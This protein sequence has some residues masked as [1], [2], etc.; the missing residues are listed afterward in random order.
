MAPELNDTLTWISA[1]GSL[2]SIVG[3]YV[4]FR[5]VRTVRKISQQTRNEINS[6][7][8]VSDISRCNGCI[9]TVVSHIKDERYDE[10]LRLLKDV[11]EMIIRM[12]VVVPQFKIQ[13]I[14]HTFRQD[15]SRHIHELSESINSIEDN[16]K[17]PKLI[18][19]GII[20]RRIDDLSTYI[21]EL[22][23]RITNRIDG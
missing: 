3:I 12:K 14:E 18:R 5:Q 7:S 13:D 8:V 4:T 10:A 20:T 21:I 2:A 17:T 1:V 15:I 23:A 9:S 11:K 6:A 19:T 22:Q 16:I